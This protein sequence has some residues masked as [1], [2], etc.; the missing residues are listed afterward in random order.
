MPTTKELTARISKA[1]K[2]IEKIK[3]KIVKDT[4]ILFKQSLKEIFKK[5][6]DLVS[7]SWSQ[8]TPHW[9]DGDECLFSANTDYIY[10]NGSDE[11]DSLWD[12]KSLYADV[13]NKEGSIKKLKAENVKLAKKKDQKWQIESNER[14]IEEIEKANL[15]ELNWK[16]NALEDINNLLD[17]ADSDALLEMFNNHVKVTAT[18]DGIETEDYEHD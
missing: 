4:G 6:K 7:F 14:K 11:S 8:Y 10:L 1:K 15:G 3:S 2:E 13:V 17:N 16:L 18:R 9:N 5:H 12:I